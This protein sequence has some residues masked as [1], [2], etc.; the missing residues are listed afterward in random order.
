M[1]VSM[2]VKDKDR[3]HN[4]KKLLTGFGQQLFCYTVSDKPGWVFVL[5]CL[6]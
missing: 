2:I 3:L 1:P 5:S 6:F 4:T